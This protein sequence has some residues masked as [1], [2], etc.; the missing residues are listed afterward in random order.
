M[1]VQKNPRE[2]SFF[3]LHVDALKNQKIPWNTFVQ[4]MEEFF[5]SDMEKLKY[6][7]AMILKELTISYSDMERSKYLNK[8]LLKELKNF[9]EKEYV[10]DIIENMDPEDSSLNSLL[11]QHV[12]LAMSIQ[13]LF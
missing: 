9:I 12:K 5:F 13:K 2:I 3:Q 7:N 1:A 11:M 6:L 8:I 10:S 4:F